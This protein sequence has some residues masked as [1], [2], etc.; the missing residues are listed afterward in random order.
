AE[1]PGFIL[2][3]L[4]ELYVPYPEPRADDGAW[5]AGRSTARVEGAVVRISGTMDDLDAWRAA[6]AAWWA[7]RPDAA[8]PTAPELVWED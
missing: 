4:D 5:R 6:C 7:A 2:G 8:E 1:R 3:T